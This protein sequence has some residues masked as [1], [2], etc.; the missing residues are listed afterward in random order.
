MF[1]SVTA[2]N[3]SVQINVTFSWLLLSVID[4]ELRGPILFTVHIL[5]QHYTMYVV[6]ALISVSHKDRGTRDGEGE[7]GDWDPSPL[8]SSIFSFCL[9]ASS[10]SY[11]ASLR[12]SVTGRK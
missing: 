3:A 6:E 4:F 2:I 1:L 11:I 12:Q 8:H 9:T 10:D 7:G 5:N